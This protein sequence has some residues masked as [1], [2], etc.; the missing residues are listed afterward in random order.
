MARSRSPPWHRRARQA[1]SKARRASKHRLEA[2]GGTAFAVSPRLDGPYEK[3]WAA[4]EQ[5]QRSQHRGRIATRGAAFW[6]S[7]ATCRGTASNSSTLDSGSV[8]RPSGGS[9]GPYCS[10][11]C[12]IAGQHP[13]S[14]GEEVERKRQSQ[15]G[16][17]RRC[18]C[19]DRKTGA[20]SRGS[21]RQITKCGRTP[22]QRSERGHCRAPDRYNEPGSW[23]W[24]SG[25]SSPWLLGYCLDS[26]ARGR[27]PQ[28]SHCTSGLLF[29]GTWYKWESWWHYS[30][31]VADWFPWHGADRRALYGRASRAPGSCQ[32]YRPRS[33]LSLVYSSEIFHVWREHGHLGSRYHCQKEVESAWEQTSASVQKSKTRTRPLVRA[34]DESGYWAH[35]GATWPGNCTRRRGTNPRCLHD[36]AHMDDCVVPGLS[37]VLGAWL[38]SGRPACRLRMSGAGDS[39]TAPCCGPGGGCSGRRRDLGPVEPCCAAIGVRVGGITAGGEVAHL[40]WDLPR[41]SVGSAPGQARTTS[42]GPCYARESL[43]YRCYWSLYGAGVA[44][45]CRASGPRHPAHRNP[46]SYMGLPRSACLV[47]HA[48]PS[49]SSAGRVRPVEAGWVAHEDA[50]WH[51]HAPLALP[52]LSLV[53][54]AVYR[55]VRLC[56]DFRRASSRLGSLLAVLSLVLRVLASGLWLCACIYRRPSLPGRLAALC[57]LGAL[58]SARILVKYR[59]PLT[60]PRALLRSAKGAGAWV[61]GFSQCLR[62]NLGSGLLPSFLRAQG[63]WPSPH[64]LLLHFLLPGPVA[65]GRP[66]KHCGSRCGP[67]SQLGKRQP[68][69]RGPRPTTHSRKALFLLYLCCV[70]AHALSVFSGFG[71]SLVSLLLPGVEGVQLMAHGFHEGRPVFSTGSIPQRRQNMTYARL[72]P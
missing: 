56:T 68:H 33:C 29:C 20:A 27:D 39:F 46:V 65:G 22:G 31:T 10:T 30:G 50:V 48:V 15:N 61:F 5:R 18:Q 47:N 70:D 57:E 1:R 8:Q 11:A 52:F 7:P 53:L 35:A 45:S 19:L 43:Q 58:V 60:A 23:S 16:T 17:P 54:A 14:I 32:P 42:S 63:R 6:V 25:H 49:P 21:Q 24:R 44:I 28:T 26:D 62:S 66:I 71:H 9:R 4:K 37:T 72:F 51:L 36:P 12:P 41:M 67:P 69:S 64:L 3:G 40:A 55:V 59:S 38:C 34:M 13:R 2:L